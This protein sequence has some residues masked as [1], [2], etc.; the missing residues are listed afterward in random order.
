MSYR[1]RHRAHKNWWDDEEDYYNARYGN[2]FEESAAI[3]EARQRELT[4]SAP[5]ATKDY[6]RPTGGWNS[7]YT[8]KSYFYSKGF[9]FSV[10][11]ETRVRQLI[12]TI[13]GKDLKLASASGWGS[14][15]DYFYYNPDDLNE[16]TDDEVLGLIFHQLARELFYS[17]KELKRIKKAE[18]AYKHLLETLEDN[19]SDRQMIDRYNGADYY[20]GNVWHSVKKL[21]T[22][23]T[24]QY[25]QPIIPALEFCYNIS[26]QA[27]NET[28]F[29]GSDMKALKGFTKA[30]TAIDGYFDSKTFTEAQV[31]YEEIKKHYPTPDEQQQKE[32][33]SQMGGESILSEIDRR[34]AHR[35]AK[36]DETRSNGRDMDEATQTVAGKNEVE[37]MA[38]N[39]YAAYAQAAT[40]YQ[41]EINVLYQLLQ[42]IIKDND[43]KRYIGR[44]KRGKIDGR[45]LHKLVM[46]NS[47]R[48]FKKERERKQRKYA[49]SILV[50][51]SGSMAGG[52]MEAA[53][54]GTVILT[55]VFN[56]LKIPFQIVGF[57]MVIRSYKNF[58]APARREVIG[59]LR[60]AAGGGTH[61]RFALARINEMFNQLPHSYNKSVFVL[62]DGDGQGGNTKSLIT[63]M[64][65]KDKIKVFGLG[66]G[67]VSEMSFKQTYNRYALVQ[68]LSGLPNA[69][70]DM[71]REQFRRG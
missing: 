37:K 6:T 53:F 67:N 55:E 59:G 57:D 31:F 38:N 47:D 10:G 19:R 16:A 50:D 65:A 64:T 12:K 33:D 25:G 11:L 23:P 49:F 69:L 3:N 39:D 35:A 42:S 54:N 51:Q 45:A 13:S 18:P 17:K 5:A 52:R 24:E 15:D 30:Q 56:R 29:A 27:H 41:S 28:D 4:E 26:V 22:K 7:G 46:F 9:D 1:N 62:S 70:I 40:K 43:T 20:L 61:D 8:Y 44:Q 66:L 68:N 34:N 58:F 32:M 60:Y 36:S 48:V 21:S 2:I 14:D 71:V 63:E